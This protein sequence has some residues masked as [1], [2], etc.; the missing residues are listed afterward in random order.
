MYALIKVAGRQY[1]V[2]ASDELLVDRLHRDAGSEVIIKDV[3]LVADG[4]KIDIGA[5]Y[6][7]YSVTLEVLEHGRHDKVMSY[8]F[9]RRGGARKMRGHRQQYTKVK[10]KAIEQGD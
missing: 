4:D 9:K 6:I 10:V 2:S 8:R 5:P 1:R 3:M 7:P